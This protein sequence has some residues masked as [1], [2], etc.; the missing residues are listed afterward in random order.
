[1]DQVE[2]T[3]NVIGYM[4]E[5]QL[6]IVETT[7]G[8]REELVNPEGILGYDNV[9]QLALQRCRTAREAILEMGRLLDE[10]GYCDSGETFSPSATPMRPGL[11]S[12]SARVR[13]KEQ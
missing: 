5:H 3:Y 8:G 4:N 1:M 9:M 7:F 6:T 12:L 2:Y 11:W 10:Y 13:D